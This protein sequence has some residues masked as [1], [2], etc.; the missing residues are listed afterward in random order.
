MAGKGLHR[1]KFMALEKPSSALFTDLYQ[2]TMV[3]AYL[4]SG[5]TGEAVFSL[6][7]RQYPP[8]RGYFV[9]AG[10]EDALVYLQDFRFSSADIEHL[11]RGGRFDE[12]FL[13]HL[14]GVSFT[15]SVRAM[16]EGTVFFTGEPVLEVRAPLPEAQLVETRLINIVNLQTILA[17]KASRV[18]AAAR[19]RPV[20]D[21]AARRTHGME[22]SHS[23]ARSAYIAG[24]EGTSNVG[25]AAEYGI[26]PVGTMAHSFITAFDS[27]TEAFREYA[28]LFPDD[29]TLLVDTYD[30]VEGVRRAIEVAREMRERGQRL[31]AVRL[32][33]GDL[34]ELARRSRAMLDEAGFPYVEVFASGGLDEYEIDRL[35]SGGAPI[36]GFGV[37]TKAGVSADAPWT[38]CAFKMV[39]YDGRPVMKLSGAK[40]SAPG[41]KQVYR[42][43]GADGLMSHDLLAAAREPAP[44][45]GTGLL[46]E[47]MRG[48]HPIAP[49]PSLAEVRERCGRNLRALPSAY[50][51]LRSPARY[52]VE[53]SGRL[54]RLGEET[55]VR[56]RAGQ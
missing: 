50:K 37:G 26:R 11:R 34:A 56:V 48:G 49:L 32:D 20:V 10:L 14:A 53:V 21:F 4:R 54:R 39:E 15:G 27:E 44:R 5:K 12:E 28:R 24:F 22:A 8:D 42:F 46:S 45:G 7:I 52:P 2:L 29:C 1:L 3:R 18:V 13:E 16:P 35:M 25:A 19:G 17:T 38:D 41:P 6:F 40:V 33:S 9:F 31:R 55:A 51:A 36:N 30:T 43:A 47:V 23:F